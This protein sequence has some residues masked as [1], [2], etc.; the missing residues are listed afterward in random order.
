M[1]GWEHDFTEEQVTG[2]KET[3]GKIYTIEIGGKEYVYRGFK[4]S[5]LEAI[6]SAE[7][8]FSKSLEPKASEIE[9]NTQL[10]SFSAREVVSRCVIW[11]AEYAGAIENDL[12]GVLEVL[13]DSIIQASGFPEVPPIPREL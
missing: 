3:Y 5:E 10:S 12:A 4:R 6:R 11:P 9:I 2:W 13:Q 1:I 8:E 7:R